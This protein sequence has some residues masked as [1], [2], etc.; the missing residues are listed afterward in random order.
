MRL[1]NFLYKFMGVKFDKNVRLQGLPIIIKKKKSKI[2]FGKNVTIKSSFF[3]M[4]G[5][6]QSSVI[7]ARTPE[8]VIEIGDN[9]ETKGIDD[10]LVKIDLQYL[11]KEKQK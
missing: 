4:I 2:S 11:K 1:Y 7:V 5:L 10:Y 3:N 6:Y 9:V 8:S